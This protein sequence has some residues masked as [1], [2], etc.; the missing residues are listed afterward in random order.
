MRRLSDW[1]LALG[2]TALLTGLV[3]LG[4]Q[5]T[6]KPRPLTLI[7]SRAIVVPAPPLYQVVPCG[8]SQGLPPWAYQADAGETH[9][10]ARALAQGAGLVTL[11][12]G[13]ACT[14]VPVNSPSGPAPVVA[15]VDL[16]GPVP[17]DVQLSVTLSGGT[18][19]GGALTVQDLNLRVGP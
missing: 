8:T 2:L 14:Q 15:A 11:C 1:W 3:T 5:A 17:A 16:P 13:A 12:A 18:C 7:S 10:E 6:A 9:Y 4:A 19:P